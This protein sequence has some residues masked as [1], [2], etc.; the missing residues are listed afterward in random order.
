VP[1]AS[2]PDARPGPPRREPHPR[3]KTQPPARCGRQPP[4]TAP[5]WRH[6][7]ASLR[8][9]SRGDA[10]RHDGHCGCAD[11]ALGAAEAGAGFVR[12][13]IAQADARNERLAEETTRS[14]PRA[15]RIGGSRAFS[16]VEHRAAISALAGAVALVAV[17]RQRLASCVARD[18]VAD[19]R[20]IQGHARARVAAFRRPAVGVHRA[21]A[22]SAVARAVAAGLARLAR[23]I[24]THGPCVGD[25]SS[26]T[27][28]LAAGALVTAAGAVLVRAER[29]AATLPVARPCGADAQPVLATLPAGAV[30]A[31]AAGHAVARDALRIRIPCS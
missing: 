2:A 7:S 4:T 25:A 9:R 20:L 30:A 10:P 23:S 12:T 19:R 31:V 13:A 21:L 3:P 15:L 11:V 1:P 16:L 29:L 28:E 6:P 27:T 14:A 8:H 22:L 5:A 26:T 24:A 17:Q 18:A